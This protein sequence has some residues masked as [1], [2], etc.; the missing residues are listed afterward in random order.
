[1]MESVDA[2]DWQTWGP[3]AF[4][5]A[6][7][8]QKPI[9]LTVGAAW[10]FG[11]AEMLRTT[12]RDVE[13]RQL[14]ERFF[15]PIWVDADDRPDIN[16][17][18]NLGG[19]PT[20]AFLTPT[21]QLLGGQTFTDSIRMA[22]LLQQVSSAY[23]TRHEEFNSAEG[24]HQNPV[25]IP[26]DDNVDLKIDLG[27][28]AW[29][30]SHLSEAFDQEYGGFG[31]A[32]KRVQEFP[33]LFLFKRCHD[34]TTILRE[35]ATKTLDAIG[36]SSLFDNIDGG[37][38]RYTEQRDW[39]QPQ[40]EKL[41]G[42][43]AGAVRVF[44]EGW[45]VFQNPRYRESAIQIIRY[46]SNNLAE[47]SSGGFFSSQLGDDVYYA[48]T[49]AQRQRLEAPV[50]DRAVYVAANGEM[51]RSLVR[52]AELVNDSFLLEQAVAT[53][54]RVM[55]TYH[56]GEGVG[57]RVDDSNGVRG[58]LVDQVAV[59]EALY[60]SYLATR[61]EVYLDL[62]QELMLFAMRT[63]WNKRVSAFVDRVVAADD[64]G[65]LRQTITPFSV[66]CRAASL[67]ARLGRAT[68]NSDFEA[69]AQMVLA[70]QAK[71][72]RNHSVDAAVY[73]LACQEVCFAET[74]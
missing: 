35:I 33:L 24:R 3:E 67:L 26:K 4:A 73:V 15:V 28:E 37:V 14:V 72:A 61:H 50:I 34:D 48:A 45:S 47:P 46:A 60:D 16:D 65:L 21:G 66:N 57:H 42:V 40:V 5:Q 7:A 8:E 63:L 58:L 64:V 23:A 27:L 36:S 29:L 20:T 22:Q 25:T 19:W 39:S 68:D 18:Y 1:M 30:V 62:A 2:L 12:Y 17:R 52:G 11:S 74:S 10:S 71:V 9:L 55:E 59:G 70:S 44:L 38:F 49:A 6:E 13:V 56:R 43:N 31:R 69:R 41:L 51:A 54:D 53:L 32:T